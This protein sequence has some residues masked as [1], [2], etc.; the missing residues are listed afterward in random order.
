MGE[1]VSIEGRSAVFPCLSAVNL[2]RAL[3]ATLLTAMLLAFLIVSLLLLSQKGLFIDDSMHLPAGYSYLLTRDYRLNQEHPPLIKLLS[4]LGLWRLHPQFPFDSPGWRQAATPED[5]EDGMTRIE[6]AFFAANAKQFEQ[7]AWYGRLPV[8]IIP[9]LLLLTVWWF[10]RQLFGQAAGLLAVFL[11]ATEPNVIG[12]SIV[13]QNDVASALALLLFVIAVKRFLHAASSAVVLRRGVVLGA[14]LGL[15][16]VTKYSLVV[17][18][19][20]TLVILIAWATSQLIRGRS[21]LLSTAACFSL[22]FLTAYLILIAFY[23]FHVNGI[24][25]DESSKIASWFYLT[26]STAGALQRVLVGLPPL[27]P[28]YFVYGIDM[29]VQD[30]RDGRTAFLLGQVSDTGWWYYF[31]VAFVLKTTIP[32]IVA[33]VG[34]LVWSFVQLL[35]RKRYPVLY[36]MLPA[37]LYLGLAMTSHLNIGVRHLLP[38]LPFVAILGAAFISA[39][40]EFALRRKEVFGVVVLA[41]VVVP[42][43][44][45]AIATYPNYL[46]YFSPLAGG[47][48]HGWQKLSDSNVET[49]QEVKALAA[50]LKAHGENRVTGIMVGGEFA[51]FYGV[52]VQ[53]FPGWDQDDDSDDDASRNPDSSDDDSNANASV[54]GASV[55]TKYV[56][57]G[58]WYLSEIDLTD[59]QKEIIDRYRNEKPEA[60]VGDS[61]FV[62][63][64]SGSAAPPSSAALSP[65]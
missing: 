44:L 49:G 16:L 34:G 21:R 19:P 13:V 43:L 22:V 59:S 25:A 4:G 40:V 2:S 3:E 56:A 50:W 41:I 12:N 30:S 17:L 52:E 28:R 24:D 63:Q 23:A 29:V 57:I 26:G 37:L 14:T 11:V 64:N 39:V 18:A 45:I 46:T 10:T 62:F 20:V 8:L 32:F 58:A 1:D 38:M 42:V 9:L 61:I 54:N 55:D 6:E 47:T 31:P 33:S 53:E 7:I 5:P 48:A 51:R 35:S 60:M 27:L 36:V 65:E 15:S